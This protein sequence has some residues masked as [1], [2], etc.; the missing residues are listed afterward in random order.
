ME[1]NEFPD[2]VDRLGMAIHEAKRIGGPWGPACGRPKVVAGDSTN[3]WVLV[4]YDDVGWDLD[5]LC[6]AM[7]VHLLALMGKQR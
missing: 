4:E 1:L 3:E 6:R 7:A 5:C 2:I